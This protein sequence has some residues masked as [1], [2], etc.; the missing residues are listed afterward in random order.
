MPICPY[1]ADQA[2]DPETIAKMSAELE[3]VCEALSLKMIDDA[4]TRFVAEK[5]FELAQRGVPSGF[6]PVLVP[7]ADAVAVRGVFACPSTASSVARR[8]LIY[9]YD[10][11]TCFLSLQ[12][13]Q[14]K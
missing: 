13:I 8:S 11:Q 4:A 10:T 1:L 3:N 5:I 2:F 6:P 14:P 12:I 7:H 9:Q